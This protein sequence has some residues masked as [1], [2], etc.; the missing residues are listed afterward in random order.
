MW[1]VDG[2]CGRKVGVVGGRLVVCGASCV[3]KRE[4]E[5]CGGIWHGI[6]FGQGGLVCYRLFPL[7]CFWVLVVV[8]SVGGV[9]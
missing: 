8:D 5:V 4:K 1:E 2:V 9:A 7:F 6:V 3:R